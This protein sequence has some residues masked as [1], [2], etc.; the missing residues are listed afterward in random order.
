MLQ[1]EDIVSMTVLI[2]LLERGAKYPLFF[3]K[4][5]ICAEKCRVIGTGITVVDLC[6]CFFTIAAEHFFKGKGKNSYLS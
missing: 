1:I 3:Y 4:L 2:E 5:N 6:F